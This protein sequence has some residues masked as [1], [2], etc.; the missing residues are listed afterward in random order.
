MIT[1]LDDK[2]QEWTLI[3]N[4]IIQQPTTPT[5]IIETMTGCLNHVATILQMMR[6]FLNHLYMAQTRAQHHKHGMIH[7]S[8]TAHKD[9]VLCKKFLQ[10]TN[11]GISINLLTYQV[12]THH[13]CSD[14]LDHGISSYSLTSGQAWCYQLPVECQVRVSLNM[15]K[16]LG[17]FITLWVEILEGQVP[18]EACI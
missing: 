1:F 10:T 6:H 3:L 13:L 2:L 5:K 7:L 15:L 9:L 11:Q 14:A 12:P 17:A 16:F 8:T 18:E 4:D